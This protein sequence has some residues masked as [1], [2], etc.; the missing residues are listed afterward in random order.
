VLY[1]RGFPRHER[2]VTALEG[3]YFLGLPWLH[4]EDFSGVGRDA[5]YLVEQIGESLRTAAV[6]EASV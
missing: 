2:G 1:A 3:L 6:I 5:A 4:T